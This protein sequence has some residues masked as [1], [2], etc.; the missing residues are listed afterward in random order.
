MGL[1]PILA[2]VAS[3]IGLVGPV[4][5]LGCG[6]DH[7]HG[8]D[9]TPPA[10]PGGMVVPDGG[11]LACEISCDGPN[12]AV[13]TGRGTDAQGFAHDVTVSG[14]VAVFRSDITIMGAESQP[15]HIGVHCDG[16]PCDQLAVG[17]FDAAWS[18]CWDNAFCHAG[19]SGAGTIIL[20]QVSP[21]VAGRFDLPETLP[22]TEGR[23]GGWFR[24]PAS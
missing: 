14:T 15:L 24:L 19:S 16:M 10:C 22:S 18:I 9:A 3:V 4:G 21:C 12:E 1:A 2:R 23:L 20:D 6:D 17:T 8:A 7:A 13:Y 11:V 5:L